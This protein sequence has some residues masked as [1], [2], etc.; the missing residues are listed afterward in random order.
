MEV[1]YHGVDSTNLN[2]QAIL[3]GMDTNATHLQSLLTQL[4]GVFKGFA[5]DVATPLLNRFRTALGSAEHRTGYQGQLQSVKNA[6]HQ[7]SG[8]EGFM[9]ETDHQQGARFMA[10]GGF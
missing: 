8:S 6:I 5:A 7:T 3:N 4:E 1:N 10:I 9:K 2:V